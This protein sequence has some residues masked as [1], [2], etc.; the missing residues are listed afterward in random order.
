MPPELQWLSFDMFPACML[1]PELPLSILNAEM[2]IE[3]EYERLPL[4]SWCNDGCSTIRRCCICLCTHLLSTPPPP[5]P[6][7]PPVGPSRHVGVVC[8]VWEWSGPGGFH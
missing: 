6:P 2:A 1:S 8:Q 5:P 3:D 4:S 7:P